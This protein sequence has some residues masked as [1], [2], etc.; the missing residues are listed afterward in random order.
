MIRIASRLSARWILSKAEATPGP[1]TPLPRELV[2]PGHRS[3][4][5]LYRYDPCQSLYL[6]GNTHE[7]RDRPPGCGS[8]SYARRRCVGATLTAS[9]MTLHRRHG[10]QTAVAVE[11]VR[12][13]T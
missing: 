10:T 3:A 7:V 1:S 11:R 6:T 4:D 2:A 13:A 12:W 5:C 9:A 8:A